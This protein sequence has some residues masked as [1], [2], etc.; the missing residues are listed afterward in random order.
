MR[1][2]TDL[3]VPTIIRRGL[4]PDPNHRFQTRDDPDGFLRRCRFAALFV[5]FVRRA[6]AGEIV[7]R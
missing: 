3:D 5:E 4:A 6:T 2:A 7:W 1:P